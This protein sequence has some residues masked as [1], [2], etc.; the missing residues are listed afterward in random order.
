MKR[1]IRVAGEKTTLICES[2][3]EVRSATWDY[4]Y[5][6]LDDG[7]VVS[8]VMVAK[9]DECG[10]Q[11]G[12]A[13]QSAYLIREAREENRKE[14]RLRTTVTLS[15][16]LRDLAEC[17]LHSAGKNSMSAVEAIVLSVVS[18]IKRNPKR[19]GH[20]LH[21]LR[22]VAEDPL[23]HESHFDVRVA[24]RLSKAADALVQEVVAAEDLNR[25]EFV[26][27]AILLDDEELR[28]SLEHYALV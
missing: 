14:K 27:R 15:Q 2:C 22:D 7:T 21:L 8:G 16:P 23:L 24:L 11:A 3:E 20:I 5:F 25:S 10:D 17:R 26:R 12:L 19:R 13:S 28:E 9:C 18:V 1:K 4:D 6:V